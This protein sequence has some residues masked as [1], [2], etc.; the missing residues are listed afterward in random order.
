MSF[1]GF[2]LAPLAKELHEQLAGARIDKIYQPNSST[3]L[4]ILRRITDT[5][6]LTISAN[7]ERPGLYITED[8]PENPAAPPAFC[9]LLRKHFEGGRIAQLTQYGLD[10]ILFLDVDIRGERGD[11]VTKR[12][13]IEIMGKHSNIIF[14]ADDIIVDAV[15]RVGYAVSRVRQV[16]PGRP[17][18]Y[19]PEQTGGN[20]MVE[21][22][23]EFIDR[24]TAPALAALPLS[25]ALLMISVGLGPVTVREIIWRS[26]LP[27]T[28]SVQ[29]IDAADRQALRE[30]VDSIVLPL[31]R[32]EASPTAIFTDTGRLAAA[33]A[34]PLEHLAPQPCRGFAT[35]NAL[36]A[37]MAQQAKPEQPPE[38][39]LLEK[40]VATDLAR[41]YKK[42]TALTADLAQ[43]QDAEQYR[44]YG[45]I[46]MANVYQLTKGAVEAVL[47]DLYSE[48]PDNT[49]LTIALDPLLTP[50]E[51]AQH[52]YQRYNKA[53]RAQQSLAEQL[54][55]CRE[56]ALYLE[57][58][59]VALSQAA[60]QAET[61]EIRQEL[62]AAGYV[63]Q[64]MSKKRKPLAAAPP[65]TA[66]ASDGT[67]ILIGR[68]NRQN[69]L[70]TFKQAHADDIWLH[71]KD[72]PGS[73]VIIKNA[74]QPP[75]E[76]A[77]RE[78]AML[79]AYFSKSRHSS[80]VPV[81][82]TKKRYVKKPSGAK[83][84]FVIYEQQKTLYITPDEAIIKTLLT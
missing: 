2:S 26:G 20:I 69:D 24:L 80:A 67:P 74:P 42:E 7:P 46:L 40:T 25:K 36:A 4:L 78:A 79:A 5:I 9:M 37:C 33:A 64:T 53:K 76:A 73:H 8:Q 83:P 34:F 72:I 60:L 82:Y 27:A 31:Q 55:Q 6:R 47:P 71:T 1:D 45:D 18:S 63:K 48:N 21:D 62:E 29:D 52:Y 59:S 23:A 30:A 58:V 10:R 51:N 22:T 70:L 16:L 54:T 68:N 81:D 35:M 77:L 11:I 50:L 44:I 65:Q 39:T 66:V 57:S 28:L 14:V 17:Y 32:G 41:L 84:G 49:F 15:K 3:L 19:P 56:E 61:A 13:V 75:S 43:A 12:L 38:K